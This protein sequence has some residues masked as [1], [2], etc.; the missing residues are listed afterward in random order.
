MCAAP[1]GGCGQGWYWNQPSCVCRSYSDSQTVYSV[2]DQTYKTQQS[3]DRL[4]YESMDRVLCVKSILSS[5]EFEKI[6][7]LVGQTSDEQKEIANLGERVKS[8]WGVVSSSNVTTGTINEQPQQKTPIQ[9]EACL[10]NILGASAYKEIV[11][12]KRTPNYEEHLKFEQCYGNTA[13]ETVTFLTNSQQ[14]PKVVENCLRESLTGSLYESIKSGKVSVPPE[15]RKAVDYCFGAPTQLFE[16]GRSYRVPDEIKNCLLSEVGDQRFALIGSGKE[17]PTD[18]E[19]KKGDKC[20]AKIN[21]AQAKF[22]P[23]PPERLPFIETKSDEIKVVAVSQKEESSN[24]K[25]NIG[26]PVHL[27]GKAAPN[28]IVNIYIFSEPL[29][30]STKAD[31][32]GDWVYELTQPLSGEKHQAYA[33]TKTTEGNTIKSDVFDFTVVAA[34][35]AS[36]NSLINESVTSAKAERSFVSYAVMALIFAGVLVILGVIVYLVKGGKKDLVENINKEEEKKVN[37]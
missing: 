26:G 10:L 13:R 21:S 30:V 9:S 3:Y 31:E 33:L 28:S 34:E 24:A 22:L 12:G 27:S 32:N 15:Q 19:R 35:T 18:E 23:P 17:N 5:S 20:F 36:Q 1:V 6:R 7:Y 16:E 8:C 2:S 37:E 14:I 11:E 25:N 4:G 29:V